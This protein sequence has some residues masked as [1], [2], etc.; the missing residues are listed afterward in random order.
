MQNI[1]KIIV[2][3]MNRSGTKWISNLISNHPDVVSLQYER[4]GGILETN[5]FTNFPHSFGDLRFPDNYVGLIELWSKTDF[6]QCAGMD[7][8]FFYSI[9]KRPTNYFE[10]FQILMNNSTV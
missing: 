9:E 3:G 10:L 2:I 7:K 6:F 8:D 1:Q 4:G 5:M